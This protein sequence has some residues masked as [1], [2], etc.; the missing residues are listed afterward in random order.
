[1]EK[2]RLVLEGKQWFLFINFEQ[3]DGFYRLNATTS[4]PKLEKLSPTNQ[5]MRYPMLQSVEF[6]VIE[7]Q[8][9]SQ[10]EGQYVDHHSNRTCIA[11]DHNFVQS[12]WARLPRLITPV[13]VYKN[14]NNVTNIITGVF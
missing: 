5:D 10:P 6:F 2:G 8:M 11:E 3:Q 4:F 1:M 12:R 7:K 9:K 13:G 14:F